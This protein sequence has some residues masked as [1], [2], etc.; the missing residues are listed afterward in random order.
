MAECR[1]PLAVRGVGV[2]S[3]S[4][5]AEGSVVGTLLLPSAVL[6]LL[7]T[8]I[9]L[10]SKVIPLLA[11][12]AVM[13]C[14]A[15]VLIVWSVM[16]G[17]L[18]MLL[19]NG[20]SF[21]GDVTISWPNAGFSQYEELIRR[22]EADPACAA[23]TP[24]IET[25]GVVSLPDDRIEVVTIRGIDGPGYARVVDF[26]RSLWWRPK[27][28]FDRKDVKNEDPRV[29]TPGAYE[30]AIAAGRSMTVIDP[31]SGRERAA[32]VLGIEL[33]GMSARLP[34]GVYVHQSVGRTRTDGALEWVQGRIIDR[35][36]VLRVVPLDDAGRS[37]ELRSFSVPV[38]NESRTGIFDIDKRTVL[39]RLDE[40][41]RVM[42][43]DAWKRLDAPIDPYADGSAGL[44]ATG[45]Q[46]GARV[47]TVLM[48]AAPGFTADQLR[49]RAE[50]IYAGFA[51]DFRGQVPDVRSLTGNR[52]IRTWAMS[53]A[54]LIGAVER[55]TVLVVGILCFISFTASFLI[56]AIFWAMVSE[57]TR[58][59]GVLRSLGATRAG[60][61]TIWLMY[62]A[63]IGLLGSGLGVALAYVVVLNINPIHDVL[64]SFGAGVWDPRVYYFTE[65]PS[66]VDPARAAL[67][68]A[69]G[70]A[71]SLLG[72]VIPAL[73]AAM[74]HPVRA[75]RFE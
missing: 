19:A 62:G 14:T 40:L 12:L 41:Q 2:R 42:K 59:I 22:L 32:A 38:A 74:L 9:Y 48:K 45:Q 54:T 46:R 17:F 53:N 56:L 63:A 57:K 27:D 16:G 31:A 44:A 13:L 75:L 23:A 55:E 33:S 68:G 6:Q 30:A 47:T 25:F 43:M 65:I 69:M 21:A 5:G 50:A 24:M 37:F 61:A 52:L 58:D 35:D 10:T 60:I 7:L 29:L 3:S 8:R 20:R 28:A 15:M 71:F 70:V 64:V 4:A 1:W 51:Q 34:S 72:A 49:D 39:V 18:G 11:A 66:K 36:V 73:R 67:V 26:D